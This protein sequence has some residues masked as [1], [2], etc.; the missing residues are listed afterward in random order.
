MS[1]EGPALGVALGV[2]ASVAWAVANLAIHRASRL[3]GDFV[4]L[5]WGQ[6]FGALALLP[7]LLIWPPVAP[8]SAWG[9]LLLGGVASG[10]GYIGMFRAFGSG[11]VSVL[12]PI[13]ASWAVVSAGMGVLLFGEAM[14]PLRALGA[15]LVVGGVMGI[16]SRT[17]AGATGS[18]ADAWQGPRWRV[19]G[20]AATSAVGFGIMVGALGPVGHQLGPVAGILAVWAVQWVVLL[21]FALRRTRGRL[22]APRGALPTLLV[23]GVSEALGFLLVELGALSAPIA[24]VAPTA[25]TAALVTVVLGRVWLGEAVGWDRYLL[26]AVVVAGIGLLAVG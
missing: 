14:P 13:V 20:A 25:S 10:F 2:G 26:A 23:L 16:A 19:L 18:A 6:L 5:L 1:L 11:P 3:A 17:P 4:P 24:V 8:F 7:A 15:V 12:S 21:P 9:W 22:L